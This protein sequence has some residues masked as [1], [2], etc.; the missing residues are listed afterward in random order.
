MRKQTVPVKPIHNLKHLKSIRKKLRKSLTPVEA[1][2][3]KN[4]QW[5]QLEGRKFRRQQSI[6]NYAVDFYCP[7]SRLAVELDG[8]GHFNSMASYSDWERT[9]YFEPS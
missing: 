1:L 5:S 6:G 8:E 4:L 2:L 9:E 7:E 3:W